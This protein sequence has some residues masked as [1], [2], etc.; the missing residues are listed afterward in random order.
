MKKLM[1]LGAGSCQLSAIHKI[2]ELGY[3]AVV[4]DNRLDS[5]GKAIGDVSVLADTFSFE[6]TYS[7]AKSLD[8]DGIMTSGTDQPVWTV[9]RV[10]H[11]LNLPQ[12]LEEQVALHVTNKKYMKEIFVNAGLPTA[13]YA[14]LREDFEDHAL[15]YVPGPYVVKPLDSQGQRGIFKLHSIE[16]IRHKLPE[17][18]K[19]SRT[20]EILVEAYYDNS[21]VTVSGWA[22]D[23]RLHILTI[24]DRV[25]FSS[26][27]HIGVCTAHECP[28]RHL[29]QYGKT[30]IDYSHEICRVFDIKNGP[31]YFQFLIGDD[32]VYLNE[33]ACRI[34][35]AYEDIFIPAVTGV[36]LL[37]LNILSVVEPEG[38]KWQEAAEV[39]KDYRYHDK[40]LRV[41]VQLFF[42]K[43]GLIEELTPLEQLMAKPYILGAGYNIAVGQELGLIE[44]AS[45]RAGYM[46]V[47]GETEAAI[48]ENL[49]LAF[50]HLQVMTGEGE[51]LVIRQER[52]LR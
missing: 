5:P 39:L 32:G 27:D 40:G 42:C 22:Q 20:D 8:I 11:A 13:A 50:D 12:L 35:G 10:A 38:S 1:I 51:N 4:S 37:Q 18:L 33:I 29:P 3:E 24:T 15:S 17:V 30:L 43:P 47:T 25:T 52:I 19:Y 44:N 2:K 14:I 16:E 41:S 9:N 49:A 28:S 31:I 46:I 21:E 6:E 23:G 48:Q 7:A 26:D 34:G 45:Q 36:D